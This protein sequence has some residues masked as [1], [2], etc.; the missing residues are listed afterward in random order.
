MIAIQYQYSQIQDTTSFVQLGDWQQKVY[1]FFKLIQYSY[2]IELD[3]KDED[4][5]HESMTLS[6]T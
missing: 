4:L 3:N 6:P 2:S 1:E 5:Y